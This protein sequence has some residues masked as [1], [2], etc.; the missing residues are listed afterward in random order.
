MVLQR[1]RV[2]RQN[3]R[4][5]SNIHEHHGQRERSF[6]CGAL[7]RRDN[8]LCALHNAHAMLSSLHKELTA[9]CVLAAVGH[10]EEE[11]SV[12]LQRKVLVVECTAV[13]TFA[14]GSIQV[15]KVARLNHEILDDPMEND[16]LKVF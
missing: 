16:A 9:V 7:V 14:S 8:Y 4:N 2:K 3:N 13:N 6:E 10:R 5:H 11:R 1:V 15:T 12:M